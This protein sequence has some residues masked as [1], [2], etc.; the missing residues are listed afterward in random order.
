MAKT[1]QTGHRTVTYIYPDLDW[2]TGLSKVESIPPR[3]PYANAHK[4]PRYYASLHLLGEVGITTQIS[5]EK[6]MELDALWE[7]SHLLP[8]I[9][10]QDT[11]IT[12]SER[13]TTG[14]SNF[15]PE[16]SFDVFGLFAD[17]L[18]RYSDEIDTEVAH[19]RL[20]KEARP[21]DW[22]WRWA[23]VSARHYLTCPLYSQLLT[24]QY[25]PFATEASESNQ[26]EI[27]EIRPGLMGIK[28]DVKALFYWIRKW[29]S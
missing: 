22:R 17:H 26:K 19:A 27:I 8:V 5:S 21:K 7:R 28:I 6:T 13:R 11:G 24:G 29:L 2:Y 15:C 4:C 14:F 10:E 23:F 9:A 18:H 20:E 3:C 16:V 1:V 25:S 12:S